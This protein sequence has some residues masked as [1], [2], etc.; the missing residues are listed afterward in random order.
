MPR[1]SR[2]IPILV[3]ALLAV[4]VAG[5]SPQPTPNSGGTTDAPSAP[6]PATASAAPVTPGAAPAEP[7][8]VGVRQLDLARDGRALP[9]TVWYPAAGE[10]GGT[11][12]SGARAAT[13]RFPVVAFSHGLTG[14]PQDYAAVLTRWAAA[15]F[16]VAAPRF[17]KTSGTATQP[18]VFDVL[19]QPADVSYVVTEVLALDGRDGDPLAGR[20]ATDRVAAAGHSAGGITTLGLFTLARDER[21]D[22]G[23][24]LAGS[25]LGVGTT[26]SGPAA[27]Q[28][29]VHGELD[30]VVS[31][32]SGKAAYDQ[33]PWPK[34]M[35]SLPDGD[36][37]RSLLRT[38]DP[39]F[40]VVVET[41]TDF[42]RW[43][44]YGDPDA[45]HRLPDGA[46]H[47]GL[48]AFD[49]RL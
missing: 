10:P 43:T 25:A 11:P 38:G 16:V 21:L 14:T 33:V 29:F 12:R 4:T 27:P 40:E 6:A 39:A 15:G 31:Y 26:F 45:R 24:V 37:G 2:R 28:L 8:A 41:T 18:D 19:N 36:H 30:E 20:L 42:L 7:F 3:T 48:A 47:N 17:P 34:A 9:V 49:D 22:A 44:L 32:A 5:C 35:L 1:R 13:G 23:I 46:G